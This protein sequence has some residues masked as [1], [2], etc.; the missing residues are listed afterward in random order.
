[1]NSIFPIASGGDDLAEE[2]KL[3]IAAPVSRYL[4]ELKDLK[5]SVTKV[6]SSTVELEATL[7]D[8]RVP[9]SVQDLLRHTSGL[10]YG[11]SAMDLSIELIAQRAFLIATT[12]SPI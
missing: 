7:E 10:V 4:P 3:D 11:R 2:G 9:M 8:Q 12:R 5:V 1:V 6:N